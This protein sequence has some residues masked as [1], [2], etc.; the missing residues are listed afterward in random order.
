V[1]L[2]PRTQTTVDEK[3]TTPRPVRRKKKTW[4]VAIVLA[5]LMAAGAVILFEGLSNATLYFC[6]ADEVGV[7]AECKG[8]K[9]FRLQGT[10]DQGSIQRGDGTIDF[11]VTYGVHPR[12]IPVHYQGSDPTDLFKAGVPVVV[13]GKMSGDTFEGD[14]ILVK[15]SEQY[16]AA[17]PGR[18]PAGAP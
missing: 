6:N 8:D 7:R 15:H 11:A 2:T 16:R 18:V 1:D 12:T 4:P 13:E 9:R 10:V 3:A 5:I 17:N 14:R